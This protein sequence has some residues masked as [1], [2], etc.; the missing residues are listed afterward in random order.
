MNL[1]A[2]NL[3]TSEYAGQLVIYVREGA[4]INQLRAQ[5]VAPSWID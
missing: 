2:I 4:A 5:H 1:A 3:M